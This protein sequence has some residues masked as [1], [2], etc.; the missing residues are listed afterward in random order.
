MNKVSFD[1][2][3][4]TTKTTIVLLMTMTESATQFKAFPL[5]LFNYITNIINQVD[6]IAV[7]V[8]LF[9]TYSLLQ[10]YWPNML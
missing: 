10:P 6:N 4:T 3:A 9:S 1:K 7:F 8:E 5:K 2:T